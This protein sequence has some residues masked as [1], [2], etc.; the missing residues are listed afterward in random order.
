VHALNIA[1]M[2]LGDCSCGPVP[3]GLRLLDREHAI[4]AKLHR[5]ENLSLLFPL[6]WLVRRV[7][8]TAGGTAARPVAAEKISPVWRDCFWAA[9]IA[10][11]PQG[12]GIRKMSSP[13]EIVDLL[14]S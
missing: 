4:N 12:N 3:I 5:V 1:A 7:W 14:A 2:V 8:Q 6:P 11:I 13:L 10:M 9:W